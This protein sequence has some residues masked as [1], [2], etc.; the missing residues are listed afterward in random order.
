MEPGHPL[1]ASVVIAQKRHWPYANAPLQSSS[2]CTQKEDRLC[3]YKY[4][5]VS[6]YTVIAVY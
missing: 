3:I 4:V 5:D 6:I 2:R 1:A